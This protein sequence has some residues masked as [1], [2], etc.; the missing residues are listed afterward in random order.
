MLR[1]PCIIDFVLVNVNIWTELILDYKNVSPNSILQ[2]IFLNLYLS[3]ISSVQ[4]LTCGWLFTTEW[5]AALQAFLSITNSRSLLKLSSI[6]LV[7][8]SNHLVLCHPLL[9]LSSIFSSVRFFSNESVL[10]IRWPKCW[11]FSFNISHSNEYS[12]LISIRI[13]W[14]DILAVHT[15][16]PKHQLFG[17]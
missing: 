4:P 13:D 1:S 16:V 17:T 3:C 8:L 11:S 5:T 12:E 15:T 6:E 10:H 9:F 7:M 2:Y 14:F